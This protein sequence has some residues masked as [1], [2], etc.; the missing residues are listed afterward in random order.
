MTGNNHHDQ[1]R[2]NPRPLVELLGRGPSTI[3]LPFW[4]ETRDQPGDC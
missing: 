2:R 4:L 3:I 1:S